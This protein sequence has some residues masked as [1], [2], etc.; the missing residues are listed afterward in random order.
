MFL[1]NDGIDDPPFITVA[2]Q[3]NAVVSLQT[4]PGGLNGTE[5][6][7]ELITGL[8]VY[9]PRLQ[10]CRNCNVEPITRM[11]TSIVKSLNDAPSCLPAL[12]VWIAP[13]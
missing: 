5:H 13:V 1:E 6:R 2:V 8:I 9:N 10:L 11:N 7:V 12:L 4:R 3:R